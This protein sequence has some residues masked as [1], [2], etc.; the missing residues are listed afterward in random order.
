MFESKVRLVLSILK[1][2]IK[3]N[4][5]SK[6]DEK[7][8]LAMV[9]YCTASGISASMNEKS[10]ELF[11]CW[12]QT[13]LKTYPK[14]ATI[15]DYFYD[16]D[17]HQF[18]LWSDIIPS[19]SCPIHQG[20]PLNVFVHTPSTMFL[21]SMIDIMMNLD[22][23]IMIA[24]ESGCGKTS[25]ISDK[26]KASCSGDLTELFYITINTNRLTNSTYLYNRINSHLSW[27]HGSEYL[28]KGNKKMYCF[29]DDVHQA[30]TDAEQ[31]QSAVEF[32]RQH[33]DSGKFYDFKNSQWQ[34]VKNVTYVG[35]FNP[36]SYSPNKSVN[37]KI[38]KH[39][40]VIAQH[41]P[42]SIET[43]GIYTK[44]LYRHLIGD[45][46]NESSNQKVI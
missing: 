23:S 46:E 13:I 7:H 39:F 5:D 24:G 29:I 8:T 15:Y 43:H 1:S 21:N 40:H 32:L 16:I 25:L 14:E 6:W 42:S 30:Q 12:F 36:K 9:E 27:L 18:N 41:F 20:I 11:N 17:Q 45:I 3:L 35:T 37:S 26:L 19:F 38:L 10:R 33:L 28:P 34:V 4:D 22:E 31:R 2:I 44:L